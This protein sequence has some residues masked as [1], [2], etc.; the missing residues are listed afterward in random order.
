MR[1]E[2]TMDTEAILGAY[3]GLGILTLLGL[4]LV[5]AAVAM[6]RILRKLDRGDRS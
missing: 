3:V 2:R 1:G 6:A 5:W 4:L